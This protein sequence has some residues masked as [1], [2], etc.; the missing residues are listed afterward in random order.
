MRISD[1]IKSSL[2][3]IDDGELDKAM[4]FAC[5]AIDG[6]A[7][8]TYPDI[9]Y[10]GER[11]RKFIKDNLDIIEL[12]HGGVNLADTIFPFPNNKGKIGIKI[13]DIVYE[14]F[15]CNLAHGNE[16]DDGYDITI[17][18]ADGHQ[19]F[20]MDVESQFMTLP[21]SVIYAL[22]LPCVLAPKNIDQKIGSNNYYY[23]DPVNNYIIDR[24]WGQLDCARKIMDFENQ[25]R[26]KMDFSNVWPTEENA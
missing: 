14:K 16:L 5:M 15:R 4:L 22:G 21:Q 20:M 2:D 6:T 8:K 10:V 1:H 23:Y 12:V 26:V 3:A 9:N 19:Q 17:Q 18:I 24:W 13:E 25:I 11:F 7:K